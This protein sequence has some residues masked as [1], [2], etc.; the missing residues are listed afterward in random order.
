[1]RYAELLGQKLARHQVQV[2]LINTGWSGGPY[3][4]GQRIALAHTRAMVNAALDGTLRDV[5]TQQEPFFGLHVPDSCPGVRDSI[6]RPRQ[7]WPQAADYDRQARKLAA[8]FRQ[9]F[10]KFEA[11]AGPAIQ[12]AGPPE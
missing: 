7:T 9:N 10:H 3:G 2:W 12:A 8:L 11:E 6:L 1:M 4:T 5:P